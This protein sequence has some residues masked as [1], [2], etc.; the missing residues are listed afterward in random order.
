MKTRLH[1]VANHVSSQ[2][3]ERAFCDLDVFC[4][5]YSWLHGRN[6]IAM[7]A[8]LEMDVVLEAKPTVL[9]SGRR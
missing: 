7:F 2:L 9:M 6:A 1:T 4:Q 8:D 5:V 3:P